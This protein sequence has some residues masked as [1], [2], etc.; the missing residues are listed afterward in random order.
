MI[1][2]SSPALRGRILIGLIGLLCLAVVTG[3]V[4]IGL[5][6]NL[7]VAR[8]YNEGWNAYHSLALLQGA[9]LYPAPPALLVNNYP[10]LS[11]L[12]QAYVLQPWL[13]PWGLDLILAGRWLSL[14]STMVI[15]L[16]VFIAA[17][18][19]L[20]GRAA[21]IFAAGLCLAKILATSSYVGLNDPQLFGHALGMMGLVLLLRAKSGG[22]AIFFAALLMGAGALVKHMLLVLPFATLL[23]LL[24]TDRRHAARFALCGAGMALAAYLFCRFL[25]GL[26]LLD[27]IQTARRYDI[28]WAWQSLRDLILVSFAPI[29]AGLYLITRADRF[30]KL[31]GLYLVVAVICGTAFDGGAGVGRNAMFDAAIASGLCAGMMLERIGGGRWRIVF[32][33]ACL[34]PLLVQVATTTAQW[35]RVDA[36]TQH[37]SIMDV[38]F[39]KQQNGPVLCEIL[40]YCYWA[41]KKAEVDAFNM[42]E[43]YLTGARAQQDL[44]GKIQQQDFAAIQ[45]EHKSRFAPLPGIMQAIKSHYRLHHETDNGRFYV[46]RP[47]A[48]SISN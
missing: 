10:P 1:S 6:I 3:L 46:A 42:A 34:I 21:A 20:L 28:Y 40:A 48:Q 18:Q 7:L 15:G 9:P 11:F 33:L 14:I 5:D 8:G 30:A 35:H 31:A 41:G 43:A 37:H 16:C 23:W 27:V 2:S 13:E 24:W 22:A 25:Y 45:L 17:R 38:Q 19:M 4:L 47:V 12:I 44:I 26:D 29:L 32:L 39:L 36:M